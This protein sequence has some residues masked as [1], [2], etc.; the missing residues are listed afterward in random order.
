MLPVLQT[1]QFVVDH[2][3]FVAINDAQI[4]LYADQFDDRHTK[5]WLSAAP[6]DLSSFNT[7]QKA[8]FLLL[9]N[10]L[11]FCYW[12]EPKWTVTYEGKSY[13]GAW[14][15]IV[16]LGKAIQAGIPLLDFSF[17][18]HID[19]KTFAE[20]LSGNVPIPLFQER[21]RIIKEI[22][23]VMTKTFDSDLRNLIKQSNNDVQ[24]L[25]ANILVSFP[26]FQDRSLYQEREILFAK[27]AQLLIADLCQMLKGT[28][29]GHV[30]GVE[31]LTACADY[32]LPQILRKL[33]ILT[34]A[35]NLEKN[36]DTKMEILHGTP[37]EVE[38]RAHTIWAV[39]RLTRE[40]RKRNPSILPMEVN[41]HLWLATQEKFPDDKPYHRTRTTA[42]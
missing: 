37:E 13:D 16:S 8:H 30:D 14:G 40:I 10:A 22:G 42:Y 12:G 33:G 17:C 9:F 6:F 11:S 18:A 31:T 20:I 35:P 27:R 41:D 36:I 28:E 39:E 4:A 25:L 5:H 3:Q 34:Y 15:M 21:L 7:Q 23:T 19:E 26:S 24:T 32:K 2:A 29:Y 38:L 1:T